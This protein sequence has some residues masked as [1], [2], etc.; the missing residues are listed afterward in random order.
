M[1]LPLNSEDIKK[2][3]PHRPPFLLVDTVE[4]FIDGERIVGTK[5]VREDEYYFPGH[6]PGNPIM[7][8][9]LV[10]EAL[11]QTGCLYASMCTNGMPPGKLMVLAGLDGFRFRA[12]VYPGATLRMILTKG[13]RKMGHW[14]MEARAEVDGEMVV[15]G[16]V[17][18][19]EV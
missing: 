8:G 3:I 17:R 7:P 4:E 5:I 6:F 1:K 10:L 12:P 2:I 19:A 18:A 9:V 11:A 16:K 14:K 15:E 13:R